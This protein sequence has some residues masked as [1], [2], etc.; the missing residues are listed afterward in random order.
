MTIDG[1]DLGIGN[2]QDHMK[3]KDHGHEKESDQGRETEEEKMTNEDHDLE[4]EGRDLRTGQRV[5]PQADIPK[6]LCQKMNLWTRK[7]NKND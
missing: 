1:L 4:K 3:R 2:D 6:V 7:R 5:S